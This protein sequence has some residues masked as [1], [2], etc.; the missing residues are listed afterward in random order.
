MAKN[1]PY[2]F[3][4]YLMARLTAAFLAALP[5]PVLLFIARGLGRAAYSLVSRHREAA[6][7]NLRF[8][9]GRT[10]SEAEIRKI[11]REVFENLAQAY[12]DVL[13]FQKMDPKKLDQWVEM[14]DALETFRK[15]LA[16]GKG[17]ILITSHLG[18]WEL[19]AAALKLKG[20]PGKAVA[21]R[22]RYEPYNKWIENLR[23]AVQLETI[24]RSESPREIIQLLRR[25]EVIGLL[26]DQDISNLRGVFVNFFGKSAHTSIAPVRLSLR[27]GAPII[28]CF[29][30]RRP[31]GRYQ[32]LI[33]EIIRPA[34]QTTREAA[35]LE[36]TQ[37]WMKNCEEM[38]R[39][40]PGQWGWMHNR[41]K[42]TE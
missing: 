28:T 35:I 21:R 3:F 5:R 15:L 23:R 22:V 17:I 13:L 24:Y 39:R 1:K 30:I 37:Q 26:P 25:G 18:N 7:R 41:W 34:I 20:V 31:K 38:I 11:A 32:F 33:G 2:R 40:Y 36:S 4:I 9:F 42:T 27:T 16:E 8:A 10:K 19:L 12:A 6:L 29:V 14:G